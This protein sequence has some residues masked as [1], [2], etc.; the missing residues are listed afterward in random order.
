MIAPTEIP[1]ATIISA[2]ETID[3]E[4]VAHHIAYR[5]EGVPR[6]TIVVCIETGYVSTVLAGMSWS[7]PHREEWHADALAAAAHIWPALT[8]EESVA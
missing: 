4:G 3:L 2:T 5:R 6:E 1:G 7:M 8:G